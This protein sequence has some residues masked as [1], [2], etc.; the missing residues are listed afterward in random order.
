M[1]PSRNDLSPKPIWP[2]REGPL[3][4]S[5]SSTWIYV[6]I[7]SKSLVQNFTNIFHRKSAV[8]PLALASID[9]EPFLRSIKVNILSNFRIYQSFQPCGSISFIS[10]FCEVK[11]SKNVGNVAHLPMNHRCWNMNLTKQLISNCW[12]KQWV[13]RMIIHRQRFVITL[14]HLAENA[15]QDVEEV[16]LQ[17]MKRIKIH[18]SFFSYLTTLDFRDSEISTIP[19]NSPYLDPPLF[20]HKMAFII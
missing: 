2:G 13:G 3:G 11:K 17:K 19:R 4:S 14:I 5:A 20:C 15:F 1:D 8:A 7:E 16:F 6:R 12:L 10:H 9:R 18:F